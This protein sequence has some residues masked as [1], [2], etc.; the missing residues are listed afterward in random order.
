M[1]PIQVANLGLAAVIAVVVLNWKRNDDQS[2]ADKLRELTNRMMVAL[3]GNTKAMNH[4]ADAVET[5]CS[6]QRIEE[7]M[8][9]LEKKVDGRRR[10]GTT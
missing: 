8:A 9:A 4:M 3:E 2:Y 1:D 10:G 6:L 7:R 5:L